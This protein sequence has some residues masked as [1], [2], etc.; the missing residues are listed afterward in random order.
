MSVYTHRVRVRYGECDMQGVVFNAH[1]LAY[2]DDAVDT[3]LRDVLPNGLYASG[4][5]DAGFDMMAKAT[6]I[7]WS[8]PLRFGELAD[9]ACEVTRWGTT[10]F[11]V[12]I[13]GTVTSAPRFV[14]IITY[15][16]VG[17]A[18]QRPCPVPDN[19]RVALGTPSPARGTASP[20]GRTVTPPA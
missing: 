9:L 6:S 4:G 12:T 7:V 14:I 11:D 2:A 19:V 15:V 1:Y 8:S 20:A 10:S 3:W 5:T 13:T 17:A 16:S 18:S